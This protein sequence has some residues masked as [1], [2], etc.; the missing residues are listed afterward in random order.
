MK[1]RTDLLVFAC[2]IL[3]A[4]NPNSNKESAQQIIKSVNS[5][6]IGYWHMEGG[7]R[8]KMFI[9][10]REDT[11]HA[12][13][14]DG[15]NCEELETLKLEVINDRKILISTKVPSNNYTV[16]GSLELINSNRIQDKIT[17]DTTATVYWSRI[18]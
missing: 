11:L 16:I 8:T 14:I 9:L 7:L 2:Y 18:K 1:K 13:I 15:T 12:T 4:C 17:G 6:F 10:Q 5:A 3:C